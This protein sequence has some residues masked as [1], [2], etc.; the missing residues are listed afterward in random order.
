MGDVHEATVQGWKL[1]HEKIYF[2]RNVLEEEKKE[3][4]IFKKLDHVHIT[5]L[6]G[7]YT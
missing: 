7:S 3:I 5:R 6:I 2:T 4:S 1:A